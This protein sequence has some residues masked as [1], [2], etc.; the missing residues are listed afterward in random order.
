ME[1]IIFK[2]RL[3]LAALDNTHRNSSKLDPH[4]TW[5]DTYGF[6]GGMNPG[7]LKQIVAQNHHATW[8]IDDTSQ[9]CKRDMTCPEMWHKMKPV[10]IIS[11]MGYG[12]YAL[13]TENC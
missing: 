13:H 7:L 1:D 10:N 8:S 3:K 6:R 11:R 4:I 5:E 9:M 2:D 12:I